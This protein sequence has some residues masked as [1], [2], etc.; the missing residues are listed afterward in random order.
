MTSQKESQFLTK[1]TFTASDRVTGLSGGTNYNFSYT[2]LYNA[3]SGLGSFNQVGAPLGVPVLE[4]PAAGVN[5][6]RN[7]ESSKGVIASVSANNGINLACN[8]KQPLSGSKIIKDLNAAQ[9]EF[10]SLTAGANISLTDLTDSIRINYSPTIT[11]NKTVIISEESDFPTP[12]LGVIT[13]EADKD[14]LI[15]NDITTANR[16]VTSRP[17]TIRAASSQMV[18]LTYSGVGTMFTSVD[19]S[20]KLVNISVSCPN[21]DLFGSTAPT[22]PGIIQMVESNVKACQ[23]LGNID[24]NFITRFTNVAFENLVL[25]GLT[26]SGA[27]EILVVDVGVAFIMGG[28]L[29][30]LGTATFNSVSIDSG[31]IPYS[32]VGTFFLSGLVNS[33]NINVGGLGTVINNKGFGLGSSL[34]GIST[35]DARWNFSSNNSIPDTR[36]DGL[37]ALTTPTTTVLGVATPAKIT[38]VFSIVRTS[39]MTATTDGRI[40]YDG[41]KNATLPITAAI[42]LEPVSGTNKD[43]NIYLAK[44]GVVIPS[45]KVFTTVSA[46]S[47]K[48]QSVVWQDSWALGDY[49]EVWIESIDGTDVQVN[50]AKLRVN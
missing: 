7:L 31:I 44:N 36:P 25:N 32:A 12:V 1:D 33:G 35:D 4:Q 48:N 27:N 50:T 37:V 20:L 26:F 3:F 6:V 23:S 34:N 11:T 2:A 45:S 9:Y 40:T 38:G 10:K 8:F 41:E 5:N 28:S 21:G 15:V 14:Y 18:T 22:Q 24:G 30:D 49:Y 16:F 39:Q 13:L 42:S 19:P 47:P 46:V 17:N 29:I 43:I